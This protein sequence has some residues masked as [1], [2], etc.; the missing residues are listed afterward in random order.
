MFKVHLFKTEFYSLNKKTKTL[1]CTSTKK[2]NQILKIKFWYNRTKK[3][4]YN[5]HVCKPCLT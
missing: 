5:M 3:V 4:I 1:S 2:D